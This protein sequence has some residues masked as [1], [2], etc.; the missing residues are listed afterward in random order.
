MSGITEAENSKYGMGPRDADEGHSNQPV[1]EI[2][3]AKIKFFRGE[4]EEALDIWRDFGPRRRPA[5]K[6]T[7]N[8][9]I[10]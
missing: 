7:G 9:I 3:I 8:L 6:P 5:G 10:W 2:V 4:G 1:V